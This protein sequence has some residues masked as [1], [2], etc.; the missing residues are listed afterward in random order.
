MPKSAPAPEQDVN[1]VD[2]NDF[3]QGKRGRITMD[4]GAAESV[5][6][7]DMLQEVPTRSS[8]RSCAGTHCIV[9]S[10]GRMP[11]LGEKHVKF[12]TGEGLGSSVLFQVTDARKP[13][14]SVSKIVKK[15]NRVVFGSDRS[16]IE[17]VLT[18]KWIEFSAEVHVFDIVV[19][20]ESS[21]D[22]VSFERLDV[23][24][25]CL[26]GFYHASL[27]PIQLRASLLRVTASEAPQ[28][29]VEIWRKLLRKSEQ[30]GIAQVMFKWDTKLGSC[31]DKEPS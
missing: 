26:L 3:R 18:A 20:F 30:A 12:R 28:E 19:S 23:D 2:G 22:R 4:S 7:L 29:C 21:C 24:I 10:G 17:N 31:Q 15:G 6:P 11:N 9:A 1:A 27:V 8:P 25:L 14:A 13:L 16:Y 5:I